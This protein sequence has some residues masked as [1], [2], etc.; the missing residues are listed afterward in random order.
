MMDG[1]N[2]I[3]TCA[4]C[5]EYLHEDDQHYEMEDGTMLCAADYDCLEDWARKFLHHG[6]ISW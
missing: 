4:S 6:I 3:G 2:Y 1:S 5:G